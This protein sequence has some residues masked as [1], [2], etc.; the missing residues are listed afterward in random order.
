MS[1]YDPTDIS[2]QQEDRRELDARKRLLREKEIADI[3]W[4]M[5]S[6]RGRRIM[7][8]LLEMSGPFRLSFDTNAMRM[9]FNEGNRNLGNQLFHEVMTLCPELYPVMV[10]EQQDERDDNGKQSN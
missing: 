3:K 6:R 1:Q 5:S 4:L 9:A 8:R 2:K 10:K 7:W